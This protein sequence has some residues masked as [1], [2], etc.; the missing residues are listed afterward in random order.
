MKRKKDTILKKRKRKKK[1]D[2]LGSDVLL[3]KY[4]LKKK[5]LKTSQSEDN[6]KLFVAFKYEG[7]FVMKFRKR[8]SIG[9]LKLPPP[10][11]LPLQITK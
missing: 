6:V 7:I 2:Y 1:N 4:G 11:P 8:C 5:D 9:G 10:L 3:A